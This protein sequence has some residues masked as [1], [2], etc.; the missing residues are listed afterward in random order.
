[1]SRPIARLAPDLMTVPALYSAIRIRV[2]AL[3]WTNDYTI[4]QKERF[5]DEIVSCLDQLELRGVQL[6]L[7]VPADE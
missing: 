3:R 1:M 2:Y 6:V 7:T 5:L 4:K